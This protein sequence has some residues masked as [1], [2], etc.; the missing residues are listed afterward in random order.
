MKKIEYSEQ[1]K[2][3]TIDE[4]CG[5]PEGTFDKYIESKKAYLK[6]RDDEAI[7]RV[8]ESVSWQMGRVA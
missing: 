2:L 3:K 7:K 8:V 6:K 4:V 5:K 1:P